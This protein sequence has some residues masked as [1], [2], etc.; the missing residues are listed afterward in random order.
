MARPKSKKDT[1]NEPD[2]IEQDEKLKLA[3]VHMAIDK[4]FERENIQSGSLLRPLF[5]DVAD[6]DLE[7]DYPDENVEQDYIDEYKQ[8]YKESKKEGTEEYIKSHHQVPKHID[9]VKA[10]FKHRGIKFNIANELKITRRALDRRLE[11]SKALRDALKGAKEVALDIS[12]S[13]LFELIEGVYV[14]DYDF[15]GKP[16]VYKTIPCF[17][18]IQFHLRTQGKEIGY[19]DEKKEDTNKKPPEQI[20]G[21]EVI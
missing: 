1:D 3:P 11:R 21:V 7:L 8:L 12:E 18:S 5:M 6:D 10:F 19:G 2:V 17:K 14:Q 4:F 9:F 16:V 20:T 15:R 13:K